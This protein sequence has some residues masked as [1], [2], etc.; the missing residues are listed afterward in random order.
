M[1]MRMPSARVLA[2]CLTVAI[3]P[4]WAEDGPALAEN[5]NKEVQQQLVWKDSSGAMFAEAVYVSREDDVKQVS[6]WLLVT[7]AGNRATLTSRVVSEKGL[8]L[9]E[10]RDKES[11]WWAELRNTVAF[12]TPWK[13]A[14][15]GG[16]AE[17]L[18]SENPRIE[19]DFRT[20]DGFESGYVGKALD[21]GESI[22]VRF[23]KAF[24][25]NDAA[26]VQLPS[27]VREEVAF[28]SSLL[29][30]RVLTPI[31]GSDDLVE[32]LRQAPTAA[33]P[34]E[35]AYGYRDADWEQGRGPS[36][37]GSVGRASSSQASFLSRFGLTEKDDPLE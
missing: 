37:M 14:D 16:F 18:K 19:F 2:C 24:A 3:G 30:R 1:I 34:E 29:K 9:T 13:L 25:A 31:P 23:G 22:S 17:R 26:A 5:K 35:S 28:L 21:K 15:L 8:F 4:A 6:R 33:T 32:I 20:S 7:P 12:K 27:S 11:G 36:T 10:F